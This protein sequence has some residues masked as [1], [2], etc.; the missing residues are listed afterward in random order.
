MAAGRSAIS[1]TNSST[2]VEWPSH[3]KGWS[4]GGMY[5]ADESAATSCRASASAAFQL[6][7]CTCNR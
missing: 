2:S 7:P 4:Y 1:S 3:S 6:S 5:A